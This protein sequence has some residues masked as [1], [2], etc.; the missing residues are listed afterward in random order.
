MTTDNSPGGTLVAASRLRLVRTLNPGP[1]NPNPPAGVTPY[2][3][4]DKGGTQNDVAVVF[5]AVDW[6]SIG[7]KRIG[8]YVGDPH[9]LVGTQFTAYG[10][11]INVADGSCGVDNNSSGAGTARSG[12]AFTVTT[13]FTWSTDGQ[14]SSYNHNA[15]S[16][17][18]Q[19]LY[20]GD[21]GGPDEL[22]AHGRGTDDPRRA[23]DRLRVRSTTSPAPRS[24]F[25]CSTRSAVFT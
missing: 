25:T 20:C 7:D 1:A 24:T 16:T 10:Y 14:P 11:G 3:V 17:G 21:S 8:L 4:I 6:T 13:G 5:A 12:G 9:T 2:L 15:T 18:G 23:L 19:A 22:S